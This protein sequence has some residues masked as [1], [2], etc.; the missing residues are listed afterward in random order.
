M[1]LVLHPNEL[2]RLGLAAMSIFSTLPLLPL[3]ERKAMA[4]PLEAISQTLANWLLLLL[5][6]FRTTEPFSSLIFS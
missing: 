6:V 1:L 5:S 3:N 2:E 4:I